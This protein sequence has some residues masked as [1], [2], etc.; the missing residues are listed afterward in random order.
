M[1]VTT[2]SSHP[3]PAS[4]RID[5]LDVLRGIAVL[6]IFAVNVKMMANGYN[7]YVTRSLWDGELARWIAFVHGEFVHGRF[8][9]IFTALFGAGLALLL[10]REK[11]VPIRIVLRRLFWLAVFG[12]LHLILLR[13][14]DILIWYALV[15]FIAIV[16][17]RLTG[18]TL[19][20][21]ALGLQ[22][23]AYVYY[24]AFPLSSEGVPVLWD[25]GP[26]AHHDVAEIMLGSVEEQVAARLDAA[27]YYVFDLFFVGGV[28]IDTLSVMLIGMAL[29]KNGFLNGQRS[30]K[31][32]GAWALAGLVVGTLDP[33]LS[34]I[35]K[36]DSNI[37]SH[38]LGFAAH[39]QYL[40]GALTWT[41]C[42]VGAVSLGWRADYFA[43]AGRTAFTIY[44]LQSV[45]GLALFS[46]LGLGLFGQLSLGA[47]ML[48]TLAVWLFFLIAAPAW[49]ARFRYGPLEWVWRSLTYAKLQPMLRK[50]V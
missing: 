40:G 44:I 20:L 32:Y 8:V 7:H 14:G 29:L 18:P 16:F 4:E 33:A 26:N 37:G 10:A 11:P 22:V 42:I 5:S 48:V 27:P 13:E 43:A 23:L 28:W 35:F 41:A 47:L 31:C 45:I 17:V 34:L 9:T 3:S 15:G 1:I 12:C 6:M 39:V 50:D 21:L 46:S 24:G 25:A 19:L 2:D 38:L 36:G 49:L 30:V